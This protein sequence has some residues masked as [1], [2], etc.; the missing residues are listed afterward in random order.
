MTLEIVN[1]DKPF[2]IEHMPLGN[3]VYVID[4]YLETSLHHWIEKSIRD[5]AIWSLSLIHI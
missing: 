1:V 2:R 5:R 3:K 4:N